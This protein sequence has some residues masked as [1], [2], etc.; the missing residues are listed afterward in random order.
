MVEADCTKIEVFWSLPLPWLTYYLLKSC[1]HMESK[2]TI[3]QSTSYMSWKIVCTNQKKN[4][5]CNTDSTVKAPCQRWDS[6]H[7]LPAQVLSFVT[8]FFQDLAIFIAP[9]GQAPFKWPDLFGTT[10]SVINSNVPGTQSRLSQSLKTLKEV[11]CPSAWLIC[12]CDR[13]PEGVSKLGFINLQN[14]AR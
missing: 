11:C 2:C 7:D 5:R 4:G 1:Y 8:P 3:R 9:Q 14:R 6:K 12:S 13:A 10:F